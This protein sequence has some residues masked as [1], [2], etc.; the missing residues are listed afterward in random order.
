MVIKPGHHL[1]DNFISKDMNGRL[2]S[3][4]T[5]VSHLTQCNR[6]DGLVEG[7]GVRAVLLGEQ[8]SQQ[9]LAELQRPTQ[10]GL[11][12]AAAKQPATASSYCCT[13]KGH[14]DARTGEFPKCHIKSIPTVFF[15][16]IVQRGHAHLPRLVVP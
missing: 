7:P 10:F 11:L 13:S 3:S 6:V 9:I 8:V 16:S 15:V 12:V 4:I 14:G 2:S 5:I 1:I